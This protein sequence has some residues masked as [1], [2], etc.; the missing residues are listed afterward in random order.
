MFTKDDILVLFYFRE[1]ESFVKPEWQ[2][3]EEAA[4]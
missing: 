2:G 4:A 1:Q 3:G